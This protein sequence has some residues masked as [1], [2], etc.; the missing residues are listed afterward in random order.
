MVKHSTQKS[1]PPYS[2]AGAEIKMGDSSTPLS[3]VEFG[4]Y[5]QNFQ[6]SA[7]RLE[8][9]PQY[10]VVG[11]KDFQDYLAGEPFP[12]TSEGKWW[13]YMQG[14][15]DKIADHRAHNREMGRVHLIPERLTPYFMYEVEWGYNYTSTAGEDVRFLEK[16]SVDPSLQSRLKED[17]WIF[18]RKSVV[19]CDYEQDGTWLGARLL[20]SPE[21]VPSYIALQEEIYALSIDIRTF[22]SNF[23]KGKYF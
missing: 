18:D 23:R 16:S 10:L 9:L 2:L 15:R 13:T 12:P 4:A 21:A 5:F 22:L 3:D 8:L 1:L 20:D 19:I 11:E 17:F 6:Q 14:W 7:W